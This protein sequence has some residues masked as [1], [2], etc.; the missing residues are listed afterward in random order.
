MTIFLLPR[1]MLNNARSNVYSIISD[2]FVLVNFLGLFVV[3]QN[4][5][6]TI[7]VIK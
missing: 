7:I 6:V 4:N 5:N 2:I 1:L 3:D